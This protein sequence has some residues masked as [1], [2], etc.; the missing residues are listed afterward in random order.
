MTYCMCDKASL[1]AE[2]KTFGT[3]K[4]SQIQKIGKIYVKKGITCEKVT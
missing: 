1:E 2:C 3:Q 4:N